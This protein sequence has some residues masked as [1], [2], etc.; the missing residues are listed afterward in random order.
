MGKRYKFVDAYKG[1]GIILMIAGHTGYIG[2]INK[3]LSFLRIDLTIDQYVHAFH[4]PLFFIASGFLYNEKND[5]YTIKE[6]VFRKSKTLLRPYIVIG[7]VHYLV[8]LV[9]NYKTNSDCLAPLINLLC[10][11]TR[12]LPI[13]GAIWFLPTLFITEM[14]W[15]ELRRGRGSA[16]RVCMISFLI[17]IIGSISVELLPFEP[18]YDI[19]PG[20]VGLGFFAIGYLIK[21]NY[22][23]FGFKRTSVI[24][25]ALLFVIA[26]VLTPFNKVN[27][28]ISQYGNIIMFW[29]SAIGIN[30]T[31][32]I[33]VRWIYE[34]L[35]KRLK[36]L[37]LMDFLEQ[38]GKMSIIYV[39]F[40]QLVI[41]I[42]QTII[43]GTYGYFVYLQRTTI[44]ICTVIVLYG[45]QKL[46]EKTKIKWVLGKQ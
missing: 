38:I 20:I 19:F 43:H 24:S 8:W 46:F 37:Y 35:G 17:G 30:S 41:P 42:L 14:I 22:D 4:M 13:A 6:Y 39:C 18:I 15:F 36:K 26:T 29:I 7:L 16:N 28:R 2:F 44:L 23:L 33:L 31:L 11:K 27:M 25:I 3:V 9:M 21:S 12:N 5:N 32:F 34:M 1:I 40:N 10:C 45:I